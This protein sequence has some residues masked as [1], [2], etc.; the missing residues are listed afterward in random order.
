MS[1]KP[2]LTIIESTA[3]DLDDLNGKCG[4]CRY[5]DME[6]AENLPP[7]QP[8]RPFCRRYPAQLVI[9]NGGIRAQYPIVDLTKDWCGEWKSINTLNNSLRFDY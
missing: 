5:A 4:T 6:S 8:P 9:W 1:K 7:G 3:I 2:N